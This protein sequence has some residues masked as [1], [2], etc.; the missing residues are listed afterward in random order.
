MYIAL[1]QKGLTHAIRLV[2]LHL[3]SLCS[4]ALLSTVA[5]SSP[6]LRQIDIS[7]SEQVAS[8][9]AVTN[10]RIDFGLLVLVT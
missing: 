4:D 1:P 2:K 6:L 9:Q 5:S 10:Y 8:V 7:H 3:R